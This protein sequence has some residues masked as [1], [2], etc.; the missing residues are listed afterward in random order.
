MRTAIRGSGL[1]L[2]TL[3]LSTA[4]LSAAEITVVSVGALGTGMKAVVAD[5]TK[6]TGTHV[7]LVLTNPTAVNQ[8]L[9]GGKPVESINSDKPVDIL[10]AALSSMEEF[11]KKGAFKA[12]SM[13]TVLRVGIGVG[14]KE[15]SAK[16]DLATPDAFKKALLAAKSVT[17]GDP[18]Q[19]NGSG[20]NVQ[21]VLQKAGI[22]DA[23]K[24]KGRVEGLGAA[25][26]LVAKGEADLGLFNASE[27]AGPGVVLAAA[28]PQSLQAYT[29]Y[30]AA[31]AAKASDAADAQRFLTFLASAKESWQKA[32]VEMAAK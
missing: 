27:T 11:D 2:L 19:A 7:N 14:I 21:Q 4:A 20:I 15:G 30:A 3:L 13:K 24:A 29:T 28:A 1:A 6:E 17:Y 25:K 9:G 23:V 26:E 32:H 8:A 10:V 16:P 22:W 31:V 12:G 5:F 18:T